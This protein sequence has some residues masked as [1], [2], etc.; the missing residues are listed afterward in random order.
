MSMKTRRLALMGAL[1][2]VTAAAWAMNPEYNS[3]LVPAY[4]T[5][6]VTTEVEFG[7]PAPVVVVEET[8]APGET[9]VTEQTVIA[10]APAPQIAQPSITVEQRRLSEDERI[11]LVVMDRLASTPNLSGKIGVES[12]GSVVTLSGWTRTSGQAYR[13][14][15]EA[16]SVLGV[17]YVQNE[18]RPRIGGSI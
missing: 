14:E 3:R 2:A 1:A 11:Q 8:L 12:R 16:R 4:T 10:P 9:V 5:T 13:A 18:I 15:R 17:K 6:T 7:P